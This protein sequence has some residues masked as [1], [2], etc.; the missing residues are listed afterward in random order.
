MRPTGG[1]NPV[2]APPRGLTG[3]T[4]ACRPSLYLASGTALTRPHAGL[5]IGLSSAFF[6]PVW[7]FPWRPHGPEHRRDRSALASSERHI[8]PERL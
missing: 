3:R 6:S 1:G 7:R 4:G 2:T 8:R 5:L